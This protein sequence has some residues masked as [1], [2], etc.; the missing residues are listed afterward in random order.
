MAY[1]PNLFIRNIGNACANT[2]YN[3][4]SNFQFGK[5]STVEL[6]HKKKETFAIV[7][8]EQWNTRHTECTRI[9]LSQGKPILLYHT[10][11][12]Y[13]KVYAYNDEQQRINEEALLRKKHEN[14]KKQEAI[15]RKKLKKQQREAEKKQ[16][17]QIQAILEA[18]AAEEDMRIDREL[19]IMAEECRIQQEEE[20]AAAAAVEVNDQWREINEEYR[21]N[22][23]VL[24]YGNI[25]TYKGDTPASRKLQKLLKKNR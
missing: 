13:W 3:L 20:A 6:F 10:D 2:V 22:Q 15:L 12:D 24:D 14:Q 17:K 7:K 8:M 19:A 11:D 4:V 21:R 1:Q 23:V 16:Q 5:I 25:A 9:M 18:A